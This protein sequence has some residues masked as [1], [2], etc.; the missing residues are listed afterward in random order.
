MAHTTKKTYQHPLLEEIGGVATLT[1][2]LGTD[3]RADFSEFPAL[4][5]SNGSFDVCD[6]NTANDNPG[7]FCE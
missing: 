3:S 2:A 5:A 1:A 7:D 4:P 6:G